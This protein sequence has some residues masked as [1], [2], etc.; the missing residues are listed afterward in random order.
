MA[1]TQDAS[2]WLALG[3]PSS[4]PTVPRP[5]AGL[6]AYEVH[7]RSY[8]KRLATV[9]PYNTVRLGLWCHA[10]RQG[11]ASSVELLQRR[12]VRW[13][14]KSHGWRDEVTASTWIGG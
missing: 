1:L 14:S 6:L 7:T 3:V 10:V 4:P 13:I 2:V 11:A 5:R 8:A 9:P 12:S